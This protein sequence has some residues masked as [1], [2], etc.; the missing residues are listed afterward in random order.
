M[1]KNKMVEE[2]P[3]ETE[4]FKQI[5]KVYGPILSPFTGEDLSGTKTPRI[6]DAKQKIRD[7]LSKGKKRL[8]LPSKKYIELKKY[9]YERD[10]WCVFCG[11]TDMLT[12]A[13]IKRRSQGGNDAPNNIVAACI[14]CHTS[15]DKYEIELP[16]EVALMLENEPE[17]L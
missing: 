8:I 12:P 2:S 3:E 10:G 16:K 13:H 6:E 15:F 11:R 1:K 5:E 7:N 4:R 17:R 9:I 14:D